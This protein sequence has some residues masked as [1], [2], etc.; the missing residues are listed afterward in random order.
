MKILGI[1][2]G[3]SKIGL[4]VGDTVTGLVEPVGVY[5][6]SRFKVQSAKLIKNEN[7]KKIII[8]V[9]GG[10]IEKE[11]RVFGESITKLFKITVEYFDETLSTQ[12]A[13][14]IM[15]EAGRARNKRKKLEDAYAACLM[16]EYYLE[17]NSY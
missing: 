12:E 1:D 6:S 8:G 2:Y 7:I 15:I 9:P 11:I 10:Q 13:Q 14:K 3:R 4:A 16:L 17:S 5:N